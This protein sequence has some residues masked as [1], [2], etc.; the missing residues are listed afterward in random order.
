[1]KNSMLRLCVLTIAGLTVAAQADVT[2]H[3]GFGALGD[4]SVQVDFAFDS[5]TPGV[6]GTAINFRDN[7]SHLFLYDYEPPAEPPVF[8]VEFAIVN[9]TASAWTDFHVDL[10]GGDIFS[11]AG[12]LAREINPAV[13]DGV[14]S[15]DVFV[16]DP[17]NHV[18]IDGSAIVRD[19]ENASL[20]VV[21]DDLV[22]PSEAF[23]LS[24]FVQ[25][26][27]ATDT[28]FAMQQTPTPIPAPGAALLALMGAPLVAFAKRRLL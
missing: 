22:A 15:G 7:E 24:F 28:G 5:A 27:G 17:N 1:M 6:L 25:D 3:N 23:Q 14:G 13:E 19:G 8:L 18:S 4:E 20:W 16:G 11:L 12:D 10:V 26:V 2:F 21:F 9:D